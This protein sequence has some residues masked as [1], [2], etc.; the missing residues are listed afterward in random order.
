M[1]AGAFDNPSAFRPDLQI[2][3]AYAPAWIELLISAQY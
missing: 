1:F 2:F 3:T